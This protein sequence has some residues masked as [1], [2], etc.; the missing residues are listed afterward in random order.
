MMNITIPYVKGKFDEFNRLIFS[1]RLPE[2]Q[3][4]LSNAKTFLGQCVCK[5]RLAADGRP[6]YYDFKLKINTRI[7]LSD[8]ELEDTIIHE[9]IHYYIALN[10]LEDVSSHGPVFIRLMNEIN[11]NFHRHISVSF[12]GTQAQR[13]EAVDTRSRYHVVAVV[14][15]ADGSSG[16]K[17]LPRILPKI[18]NYHRGILK[19]K[20]VSQ[21]QFYMSNHPFFNRFPC[22]STL[23]VHLLKQSDFIDYLCDA[24]KIEDIL[25]AM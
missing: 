1:G 13:E 7:T 2:I 12:R 22:S 24:Q 21:V 8:Q 25:P 15:F 10:R 4:Q 23:K 11:R 17:V 14:L 18:L 6:E 19:D 5:K 3:V 20:R 16:I 9:M